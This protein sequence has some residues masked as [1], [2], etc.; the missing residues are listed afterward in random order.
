[1]IIQSLNVHWWTI[2]PYLHA[3]SENTSG[4]LP[5]S[6]KNMATFPNR[7][8]HDSNMVVIMQTM[9][10]VWWLL[11]CIVKRVIITEPQHKYAC[12]SSYIP[13]ITISKVNKANKLS[14]EINGSSYILWYCPNPASNLIP[15]LQRMMPVARWASLTHAL[16]LVFPLNFLFPGVWCG[17]R[18]VGLGSPKKLCIAETTY[19]WSLPTSPHNKKWTGSCSW[20]SSITMAV[21]IRYGHTH[22]IPQM[23]KSPHLTLPAA[24]LLT[25][26]ACMQMALILHYWGTIVHSFVMQSCRTVVEHSTIAYKAITH[27]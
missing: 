16:A 8:Q 20:L 19:V 27:S 1:M 17:V 25:N 4:N 24:F 23:P 22:C 18:M 12:P 11:A 7:L 15:Y 21:I 2:I 10:H 26:A 9:M 14:N 5:Q 3:A 6:Y 13:I